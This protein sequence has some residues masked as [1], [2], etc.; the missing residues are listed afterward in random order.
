MNYALIGVYQPLFRI[1][2]TGEASMFLLLLLHVSQQGKIRWLYVRYFPHDRSTG[3]K[4]KHLMRP[5]NKKQE[6]RTEEK[7]TGERSKIDFKRKGII[8]FF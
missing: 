6:D 4:T 3:R 1:T 5:G 7:V 8:H 2:H